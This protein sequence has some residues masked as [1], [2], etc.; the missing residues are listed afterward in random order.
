MKRFIYAVL[1]VLSIAVV[2]CVTACSDT[3]K[4]NQAL[5]CGFSDSVREISPS[6]EYYEWNKDP[7]IDSKQL[8]TV[9]GL[10]SG[11]EYEGTYRES[12][13]CYGTY[14]K[15]HSYLDN[16]NDIFEINDDG[17]LTAYF[18][19]SDHNTTETKSQDECRDIALGFVSDVFGSGLN[20][21]EERILYN[22]ERKLYTFEYVKVI[23]NME[24]EDKI[25]V[26]VEASGHIYSFRASLFGKVIEDRVPDFDPEEI[27][28]NV[29]E[30]LDKLTTDAR[31]VYDQIDYKDYRYSI[32]MISASRYIILCDV[33][34]CCLS[35]KG[36]YNS[37]I[38]EKIRFIIPIE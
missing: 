22:A 15:R 20:D 14:E 29:S 10:V 18:W 9:K 31:K 30:K 16:N 32:S 1:T 17:V 35:K 4:I 13:I 38:S 34:V 26:V 33:D 5:I 37:E 3:L 6:L 8:K 2:F 12:D 27:Q 23:R 24:S 21:Y 7:Y 19:G 11:V 28:K 25:S 36:E